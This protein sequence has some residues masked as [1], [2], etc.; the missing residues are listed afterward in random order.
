MVRRGSFLFALTRNIPLS[1]GGGCLN[2]VLGGR[3]TNHLPHLTTHALPKSR[4]YGKN[5]IFIK[6]A[7]WWFQ[8][9][10]LIFALFVHRVVPKSN[11]YCE[12]GHTDLLKYFPLRKRPHIV[13]H[14]C[15]LED[16][17]K[18]VVVPMDGCAH[19]SFT[20]VVGNDF[21][22]ASVPIERQ[23]R[24]HFSNTTATIRPRNI[25]KDSRFHNN[26]RFLHS[27]SERIANQS[28]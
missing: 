11:C 5:K 28:Q 27:G 24:I 19:G 25:S 18:D 20:S 10:S 8:S 2:F 26:G 7:S 22:I 16:A 6:V 9:F 15:H 17:N 4:P 14:Q 23:S 13:R 3:E 21:R 12:F 1:G